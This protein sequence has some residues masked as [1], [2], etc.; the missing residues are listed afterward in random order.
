MKACV[1]CMD[2]ASFRFPE[3]IRSVSLVGGGMGRGG[4]GGAGA[5]TMVDTSEHVAW[6]PQGV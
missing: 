4:T 2:T 5:L 1:I 6:A 3:N